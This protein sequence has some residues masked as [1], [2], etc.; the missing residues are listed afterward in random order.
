MKSKLPKLNKEQREQVLKQ[1]DQQQHD[2]I[3]VNIE[4]SGHGEKLENLVVH[5]GVWNPAIVSARYHASY[6][7]YNNARLYEGKDVLDM[8]TGSGIM[9]VVMGLGGARSIIMSDIS[10]P[11][12]VN[13]QENLEKFGLENKATVVHSDLFEN[14]KGTFDCIVF[15]Q[16]YFADTPPEG[17]T[18]SASMLADKSLVERFLK[19]VSKYLKSDGV[20][21]MPFY[22]KA[23]DV[24]NPVIQGP[25]YGF[26]V[27]TTFKAISNYGLHTGEI[28]IHE[29]KYKTII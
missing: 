14:I 18:I 19:N 3:E 1:W 2:R 4:L 26:N 22:T 13:A 5:K 20:I 28:T 21:I 23:G 15:M 6:L 11:A 12:I 7:Y 16:P 25:K 9:S 29:L 24:N 10:K 27:T 17:D 8:G